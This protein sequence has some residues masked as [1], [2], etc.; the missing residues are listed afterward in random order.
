[1]GDCFLSAGGKM[2][3]WGVG[4]T[5]IHQSAGRRAEK[6]W[7]SF[8]GLPAEGTEVRAVASS[9]VLNLKSVGSL[10]E[11]SA[12]VVGGWGRGGER[13]EGLSRALEISVC[14]V[15]RHVRCATED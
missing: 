2:G 5:P 4:P 6:D 1:M 9:S 15:P 11:G 10:K 12:I 14:D 3:G 8:S 13:E 7:P